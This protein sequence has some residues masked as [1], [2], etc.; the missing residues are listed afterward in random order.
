MI[1]AKYFR[2]FNYWYVYIDP[3]FEWNCAHVC[4]KLKL[5]KKEFLLNYETINKVVVKQLTLTLY[6]KLQKE[7]FS[8]KYEHFSVTD[9]FVLSSCSDGAVQTYVTSWEMR[10]LSSIFKILSQQFAYL[11]NYYIYYM[12]TCSPIWPSSYLLIRPIWL[13]IRMGLFARTLGVK[14]WKKGYC[15]IS[16]NTNN[17][18]VIQLIFTL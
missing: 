5:E 9:A 3:L 13:H 15:F 1:S 10:Y 17:K 4:H 14:N 6:I 18:I 11:V 2:V 12:A 8:A 7:L 16:Q